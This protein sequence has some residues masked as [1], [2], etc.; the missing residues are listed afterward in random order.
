MY[1]YLSVPLKVFKYLVKAKPLPAEQKD[2]LIGRAIM[3]VL[4]EEGGGYVL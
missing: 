3:T 2:M 4:A 1:Y